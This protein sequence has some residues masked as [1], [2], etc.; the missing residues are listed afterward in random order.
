MGAPKNHE[1]PGGQ[2]VDRSD[3]AD[4]TDQSE[5][6]ARP[7]TL[8]PSGGYRRL[9]SFQ[10]ATVIYDATVSFCD[11][12]VNKRSRTHDQMVQAARS[13]R[14]NIAEGSRASAASSQTELRLV[15]VARASLDELLLDFEDFLRQHGLPQ[16]EKDDPRAREVREVGPRIDRTDLSDQTD[17]ADRTDSEAYAA[18]L[19]RADSAVVAN[20]I[21]CLIHQA[22]YLLDRQIAG[23]ERQFIQEGGYTERLAAARI[24]E[25]RR[26]HRT[27][28]TDP[29]ERSDRF[30][31]TAPV[32][33]VCGGPMVLR[34]ARTGRNVGSQFWG[35]CGYPKCKGVRPVESL[36]R[37][38]GS[39]RS[40]RSVG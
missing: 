19:A 28:P 6:A 14:Q 13:G 20:A 30:S 17:R 34:M 40:D 37:S 32:C 22:N 24:E 2:R 9:R 7:K 18:W 39:D 11:R 27:D 26:Q 8:R 16:W 21:I 10:V 3:R 5:N 33:P 23:L 15:N 31:E 25:R 38:V 29:T 35:C 4:R 36:D 1:G 12:F